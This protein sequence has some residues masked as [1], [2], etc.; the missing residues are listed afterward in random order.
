MSGHQV[1]NH[2][3]ELRVRAVRVV[4]VVT[5][6]YPSQWSVNWYSRSTATT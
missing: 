2:P 3:R 5:P 6:D 1:A 4:T